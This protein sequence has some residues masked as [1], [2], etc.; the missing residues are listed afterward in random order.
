MTLLFDILYLLRSLSLYIYVYIKLSIF[1][2][3]F[4]QKIENFNKKNEE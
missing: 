3:L 2:F 1:D 4:T